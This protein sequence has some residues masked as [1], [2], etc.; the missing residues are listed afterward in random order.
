MR[1]VWLAVGDQGAPPGVPLPHHARI[2]A[3]RFSSGERFRTEI[4]PKPVGPAKGWDA[5]GSRNARTGEDRDAGVRTDSI[6]QRFHVYCFV[7]IAAPFFC[8][9]MN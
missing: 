3:E 7:T 2:A 5:A 4:L 6:E 9:T 8:D 1:L